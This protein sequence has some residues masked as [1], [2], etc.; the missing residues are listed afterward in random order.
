SPELQT[1]DTI[2]NSGTITGNLDLGASNDSYDGHSGTL[3]GT[4]SAG[5][6]NDTLIGGKAADF[7]YG[8]AGNDTLTGNA[9]DDFLEGGAGDDPIDGGSGFDAASYSEAAAGVTVD[10]TIVGAQNTGG[11]GYD[12]LIGIED[13]V[14]SAFADTLTGDGSG[15]FLIGND[16]ND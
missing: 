10:L 8:D 4:I 1:I 14:G 7:F 15:N 16:G 5:D 2:V 13:L 12:T 3:N 6:G 9:G 11:A